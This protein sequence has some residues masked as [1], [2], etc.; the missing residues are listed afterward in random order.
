MQ[1]SRR[2]SLLGA[3]LA[4]AATIGLADRGAADPVLLRP[5][6]ALPGP[7]PFRAA[8]F[9]TVGVFD[10]DWLEDARYQRLLDTMEASPGAF[11][12][13]R[14]FG[15]LNAGSREDD[16]PT[17]SGGTWLRAGGAPDFT[18]TLRILEGLVRRGLV[19]FVALTF[20][21]PAVSP[22]P[23]APPPSLDR[24]ERL[25]RAFIEAA[26]ARFGTAELSRW[27]LETWNEPNMPQ[28]W[29]GD[30]GRYL[31]LYRATARAVGPGLRLGGPAI[32]WLPDGSGPRLMERFLRM[33]AEEPGLPCDFLSF[34]RKGVWEE[35]EGEP[36]VSRLVGAAEA[37]AELAL[38]LVP[39][40]CARGLAIVNNE[41][42]MRVGFQQPYAP[43]MSE[44]F[45]SWLAA[46]ATAHAR[47][48]ARYASRGLRF[49]AAADNANQH[50]VREPFD[51]RRALM[52]PMAAGR[53]DDLIKLPVFG[54][55]EMLRLLGGGLCTAEVL[56]GGLFQL[57][58]ADPGRI[59]AMLTHHPA[60]PAAATGPVML[61]WT[62]T[63]IPWSRVNL[64]IFR[65]DG[66]LSNAF[67]AAGRRMPS[68]AIGLDAAASL[69]NDAEL[70]LAMP[71][72]HGIEV[73]GGRLALPLRLDSFATVLVSVTPFQPTP[74]VAPEWVAA[75]L[76]GGNA[77]LRWRGGGGPDLL[78]YELTR[79]DTPRPAPFPL[80]GEMWVDTAPGPS[81]RYAVRAVSMSGL[82]SSAVPGPDL[83][84]G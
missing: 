13:V 9:N 16:F 36:Q 84:P 33:L 10:A 23:I 19:P 46:T 81:P 24:W 12:G 39:E 28:F 8:E 68:P 5:A 31:D 57:V 72:R 70:A 55:Y 21:P 80:R 75:T 60:D 63:D 49:V 7:H 29:R 44:R 14:F 35:G 41:A 27:W 43:R 77:V 54:F 15:A 67:A 74:P 6:S 53:P 38:R 26:R 59:G 22:D 1:P 61:D 52:T 58:T 64:V 4:S 78:G 65:I 73:T 71:P 79:L 32:A 66:A 45:P 82:R 18:T 40:R 69:R 62:L 50:L 48:S 42:D 34:H 47:L 25:V 30:F 51:G 37:T 3:G 56:E 83:R 17:A 11:G 76:S 20:F 2:R